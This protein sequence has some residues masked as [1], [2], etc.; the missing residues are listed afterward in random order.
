MLHR[1][2]QLYESLG[3]RDLVQIAIL[4]VV[5]FGFLR[6]LSKTSGGASS[7]GRGLGL[8]IVGLFLLM[9]VTIAALDLPELS[10]VLDYLLTTA[11]LGLI[12][13]FQPELRRG[14]MM[15]GR[16]KIWKGWSPM[17]HSIADPLAHAAEAMS[18]DHV[19]ALI[20]IQRDMP[21]DAFADTGERIE[22]KISARLIRNLFMPKSPLH[23][24][25][26]ILAQ[27]RIV[28]AACQLP[29]RATERVSEATVKIVMGMRH[30]AAICLS[31]ETDAIVLVVSEETGRISLCHAGKL[32]PVAREHLA[33]R[34]ADLLSAPSPA[35]ILA[36]AA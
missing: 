21:L 15:L 1:L 3:P 28:A 17:R 34:L 26:V 9:Q 5:L 22:G 32:E 11:L 6:F 29:M 31:E 23:D 18:R 13:I 8:C 27:G 24:G 20:C 36:K 10:T 30:R 35:P 12:I 4:A 2:A 19:G 7:L 16:S 33:R 25:A 14:L